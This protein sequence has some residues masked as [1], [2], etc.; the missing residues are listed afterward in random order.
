MDDMRETNSKTI[1]MISHQLSVAASCDR[2]LVM[3]KG[4]IIQ[5][6]NHKDLVKE[7]GLYQKLWERELAS[8][9]VKS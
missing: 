2:I 6:G 7:R 5:E 4:E 3:D 9:I 1:L 8:N